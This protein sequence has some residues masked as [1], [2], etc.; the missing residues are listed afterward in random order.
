AREEIF[1]PVL[2]VI[3]FMDEEDL[4]REANANEYGLA[5]SVWTRDIGKA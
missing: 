5:G 1:G 2:S 3:P 4:I